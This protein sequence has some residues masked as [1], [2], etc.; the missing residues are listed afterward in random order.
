MRALAILFVTFATPVVAAD[1]YTIQVGSYQKGLGPLH[2][3][4]FALA[5]HTTADGEQE[6][7]TISWQ[8]TGNWRS[9]A[10]PGRNWSL[11]ETLTYAAR[12]GARVVWQPVIEVDAATW[13]RF[14]ERVLLLESGQILYIAVEEGLRPGCLNCIGAVIS[15]HG[16]RPPTGLRYGHRGSRT[17]HE[18]L[19]RHHGWSN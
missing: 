2:A 6:R 16:P 1:T 10:Q 13:L 12:I 14:H 11:D 5:T 18:H 19:R 9:G 8:P 7:L 3:H 15:I 17:A 4:T